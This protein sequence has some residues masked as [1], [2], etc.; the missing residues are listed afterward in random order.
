LGII[1]RIRITRRKEKIPSIG[2]ARTHH[3]PVI[4]GNIAFTSQRQ[5]KKTMEKITSDM[6]IIILAKLSI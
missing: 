4:K 6:A 2:I 1:L 3:H 5:Q